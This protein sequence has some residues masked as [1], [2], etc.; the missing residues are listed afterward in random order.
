MF[1]APSKHV[2]TSPF[3]EQLMPKHKFRPPFVNSAQGHSPSAC[4]VAPDGAYPHPNHTNLAASLVSFILS[5]SLQLAT[6]LLPLKYFTKLFYLLQHLRY[7]TVCY[8][9]TTY[10]LQNYFS[11]SNSFLSFSCKRYKVS[12]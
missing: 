4:S 11:Y 6:T 9:L 2:T 7:K 5:L 12:F 3:S 10:L 8:L 1:R